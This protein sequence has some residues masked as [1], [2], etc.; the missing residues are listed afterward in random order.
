MGRISGGGNRFAL[1]WCQRPDVG[2]RTA[3]ISGIA[4]C[5]GLSDATGAGDHARIGLDRNRR[6]RHADALGL[7]FDPRD[8]NFP[9]AALTMAAVP[10]AA[11]TLLNR[12]KKG[13][14]PMAE[15]IFAGVFLLAAIYTGPNEGPENWQS[16]WTCAAYVLLG[17]TLWRARA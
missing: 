10:F 9:F 4:G 16:L 13:I 8:K 11:M 5:E 14:R 17:V 15:S 6:D 3:H 12:P 7:V 1:V 2:A